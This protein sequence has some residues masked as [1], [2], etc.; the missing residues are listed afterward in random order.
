MQLLHE[1]SEVN[2][3]TE[4]SEMGYTLIVWDGSPT[5]TDGKP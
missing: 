4:I 2:E 5:S 3:T 1:K